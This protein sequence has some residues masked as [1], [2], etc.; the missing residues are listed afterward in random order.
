[1]PEAPGSST[2]HSNSDTHGGRSNSGPQGELSLIEQ[3]EPLI[4]KILSEVPRDIRDDC[5]QAAIIGLLKAE[6][7]KDKVKFYN[8]YVFRCMKNE[9]IK[10]IANLKGPGNGLFCLDK[11]TFLL[12]SKYKRMKY[13]GEDISQLNLSEGRQRDLDK[14]LSLSNTQIKRI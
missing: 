6:K 14:L 5:Y 3:Y 1:M 9:V 12:L 7:K 13:T 4:R 11:I 10:E 2:S 8:S